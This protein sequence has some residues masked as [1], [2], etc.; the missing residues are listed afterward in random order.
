MHIHNILLLVFLLSTNKKRRSK[1]GNKKKP[2][3]PGLVS[4]CI[5]V[6]QYA[7]RQHLILN[8]K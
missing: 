8:V 3:T 1:R 5:V 4:F 6:Q 2:I 7:I